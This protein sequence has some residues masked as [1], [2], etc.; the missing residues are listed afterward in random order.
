MEFCA[1]EENL[2]E[3]TVIRMMELS[4]SFLPAESDF[5]HGEYVW[6]TSST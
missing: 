5:Y 6:A 4:Y 3:A 1:V 2:E